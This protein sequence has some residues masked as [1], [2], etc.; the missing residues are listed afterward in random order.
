MDKVKEIKQRVRE[1]AAEYPSAKY[2]Q[3]GDGCM[4]NEGVVS[5][6][7]ADAYGCIFGNVLRAMDINV[8]E[9]EDDMMGIDNLLSELGFVPAGSVWDTPYETLTPEERDRV[10]MEGLQGFQ[11][12]GWTWSRAVKAAD[13][14]MVRMQ[15]IPGM[16]GFTAYLEQ[17]RIENA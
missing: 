6:G 3:T 2:I 16:S 8:I 5:D 10:W 17:V 11:D 9:Y 4:Y 14:M 12:K 1:L 13:R 7:P 15:A